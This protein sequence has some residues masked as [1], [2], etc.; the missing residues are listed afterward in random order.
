MLA[1]IKLIRDSLLIV[2]ECETG[3]E[4]DFYLLGNTFEYC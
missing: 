2:Q 4:M 1:V 3:S